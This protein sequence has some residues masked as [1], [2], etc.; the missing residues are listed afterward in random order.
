MTAPT[1][2]PYR[3]A[4]RAAGDSFPRLLH[5]EWTKF[6]T[7]RGWVIATLVAII[8]TVLVGLFNGSHSH[9]APCTDGPNGSACQYVIPTGPGGEM[10][11]DTLYFVDRPLTGDAASRCG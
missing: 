3:S 6:R 9:M 1:I 4:V 7:V 10:V 11:T 2:T 5:A 8:V